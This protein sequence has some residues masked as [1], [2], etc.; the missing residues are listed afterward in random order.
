[1]IEKMLLT[2][3]AQ[4]HLVSSQDLGTT[5]RVL[6]EDLRLRSGLQELN[7]EVFKRDQ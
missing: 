7:H 6:S 4:S 2:T 5:R 3:K 1:M